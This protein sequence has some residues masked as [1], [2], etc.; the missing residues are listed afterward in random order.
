MRITIVHTSFAVVEQLSELF[1]EL[2]PDIELHHIVDDSLLPEILAH[3]G[4]TEPVRR[5]LLSYFAAAEQTGADVVFSQCSSVGDV[6]AEA[7]VNASVPIVRIDAEMARLACAAGTRIGVL[8]TLET[9][10]GPT[11]R[12]IEA[13]A[14]ELGREVRVEPLRVDGAFD[15][16]AA[17]DFAGHDERVLAAVRDL[18]ESV[19]IVVLAQGTMASIEPRLGPLAS[20]VLSSPRLGAAA[21]VAAARRQH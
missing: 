9:T 4:V 1:A 2:A 5:R 15:L 18:A 3:G 12:L 11:A 19:D 20:R 17:G 7:A 21:A 16:R 13:T 6:A 10:L 14:H 8:A